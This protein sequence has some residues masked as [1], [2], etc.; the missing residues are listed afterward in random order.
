MAE[1]GWEM[2]L[3]APEAAVPGLCSDVEPGP[4]LFADQTSLGSTGVGWGMESALGS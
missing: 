1:M 2:S 3:L 4:G